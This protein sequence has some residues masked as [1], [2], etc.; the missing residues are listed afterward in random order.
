[1][2]AEGALFVTDQFAV[3]VKAPR[4]RAVSTVGAGDTMT[5]VLARWLASRPQR[6]EPQEEETL[7]ALAR[8][9]VAAATAK[10]LPPRPPPPPMQEIASLLPGVQVSMLR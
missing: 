6:W 4:V 1:M 5:A 8:Q 3:R 2:G 9:A 7:S 10:V